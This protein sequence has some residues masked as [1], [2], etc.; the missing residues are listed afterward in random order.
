MRY[1]QQAGKANHAM[2]GGLMSNEDGYR[3]S[4]AVR[5]KLADDA[6]LELWEPIAQEFN[7]A[8]PDAAREYLDAVTQRLEEQVKRQFAEFQGG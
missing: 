6:A 3:F 1:H 8:G 7:R 5:A 2:T 4:E